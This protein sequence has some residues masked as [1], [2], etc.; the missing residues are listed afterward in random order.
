VIFWLERKGL[1][2]DNETVERIF[3][4]AKQSN[5]TLLDSEIMECLPAANRRPT[6]ASAD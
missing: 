6:V 5:R 4:R 2:A 1:T 3:Q